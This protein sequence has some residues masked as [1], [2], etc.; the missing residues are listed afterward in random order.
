MSHAPTAGMCTRSGASYLGRFSSADGRPCTKNG[1]QAGPRGDGPCEC[2]DCPMCGDRVP[3]WV[4]HQNP[5]VDHKGA[6]IGPHCINCDVKL[7]DAGRHVKSKENG[8]LPPCEGNCLYGDSGY[9]RWRWWEYDGSKCGCKPCPN[10]EVCRGGYTP[11]EY[12][13][14]GRCGGCIPVG[15]TFAVVDCESQECVI[16]LDT[17]TRGVKHPA[18]CG[19]T[20]CIECT[21][22]IWYDHGPQI[23]EHDYGLP[24]TCACEWC[25]D[26]ASPVLCWEERDRLKALAPGTFAQME[27]DEAALDEA[28]TEAYDYDAMERVQ[29][30]CPVCRRTVLDD[31]MHAN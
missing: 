10:N 18:G 14:G 11:P 15:G 7:F 29:E 26:P 28:E 21:R 13:H 27:K 19:H 24:I 4:L 2:Q 22:K 23:N 12:L 31:L 8:I 30:R 25:A 6:E 3:G 5:L 1:C 20:L 17:Y 16:C 9:V